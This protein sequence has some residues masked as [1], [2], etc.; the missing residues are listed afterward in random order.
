MN[1]N[2]LRSA[3]IG[4]PDDTEILVRIKDDDGF[5]ATVESA[6]LESDGTKGVLILTV[7]DTQ[8]DEE[9]E[10]SDEEGEEEES[11][12]TSDTANAG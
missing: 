12:E 3:M 7:D 2:E 10:E 4:A 6:V 1:I 8:E 11:E 9:G 5:E